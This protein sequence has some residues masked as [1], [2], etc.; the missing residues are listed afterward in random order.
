LQIAVGDLRKAYRTSNQVI[1]DY[2]KPEIQAAYLI[3]YYPHYAKMNLEILRLLTS[4]FNFQQNLKACFFGAGPCPEIVG[5]SQFLSERSPTTKILTAYV[6]DIAAETWNLSRKVTSKYI[7]PQIWQGQTTI[8]CQKLDLC[9]QQAFERIKLNI[10]SSDLFIFQNCL[11][12]IANTPIIQEN[13]EF[14]F[15]NSP[16]G[17]TIVVADLSGYNRNIDVV[18]EIKR[19]VKAR[20]DYE[21]LQE[22]N[23]NIRSTLPIPQTLRKHLLTREGDLFP[24]VSTNFFYLALRKVE[25]AETEFD[26]IPF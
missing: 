25:K 20:N 11:N 19:K 10:K 18:E 24:R 23:L 13:L 3:A 14:L 22:G 8:L 21:I 7:L 9:A 4:E 26:N 17:A 6:Y 15:D 16:L 5:L 2:S 1:I 12:E